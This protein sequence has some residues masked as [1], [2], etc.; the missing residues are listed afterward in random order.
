MRKTYRAS[1]VEWGSR[2]GFDQKVLSSLLHFS[3]L[4]VQA[5]ERKNHGQRKVCGGTW[6]VEEEMKVKQGQYDSE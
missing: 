1:V 2:A 4:S 6:G 3:L 5:A